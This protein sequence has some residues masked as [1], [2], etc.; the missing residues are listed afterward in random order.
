MLRLL[1]L[2]IAALAGASGLLFL[3]AG[4]AFA[5]HVQCG[6][7]IAQDTMLDSDLLGCSG[8]GLTITGPDVVLDLNGHTVD[9]GIYG[10][11]LK[12]IDDH[13]WAASPRAVVENGTV[14]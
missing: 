8:G 4:Q 5:D 7:A 2:V 11:G 3:S 14:K 12:Q 10:N 9:G 13:T 1:G 6:D